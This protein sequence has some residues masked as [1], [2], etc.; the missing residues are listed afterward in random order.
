MG[1]IFNDYYHSHYIDK[2]KHLFFFLILV[3]TNLSQAYS[4]Y[5]RLSDSTFGFS[6]P[7]GQLACSVTDPTWVY[8]QTLVLNSQPTSVE[9]IGRCDTPLGLSSYQVQF[10]PT[11]PTCIFPS[12]LNNSTFTCDTVCPPPNT[13]NSITGACENQCTSKSGTL[14]QYFTRYP[15]S[16]ECIDYCQ[17]LRISGN[18]G[19]NELGQQG[20]YL[21]GKFNG[22]SCT[23]DNSPSALYEQGSPAEKCIK[24]GKSYGLVNGVVVCTS[25]GTAGSSPTS[26]ISPPVTTTT[27][28]APTVE[29]PNPTST[30]TIS[31]STTTITTPA[32]S[33]SPSGTQPTITE[34]KTN[35]DGSKIQESGQKDDFCSKNPNSK[36]CKEPKKTSCEENPDGPQCKH[37][38]EKYPESLSCVKTTDYIG[39]SSTLTSGEIPKGTVN[40][41][42]NIRNVTLTE[43][44][45]CPPDYSVTIGG[46]VIPFSYSWLCDYASSFK[47]LVVSFALLAA[48]YIVYGAL[49][50]S[51]A[52]VQGRLF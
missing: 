20:C 33:G 30:T 32:P 28:P 36:L 5:F 42:T 8:T 24:S 31:P 47:P 23:A 27:T 15:S 51:T 37:F 46:R 18:C 52:P 25:A 34:T 26:T 4:G 29:N 13:I 39:D 35:S 16:T 22:S 44:N 10:V 7:S 1:W 12:V 40:F 41:P 49:Q 3:H 45:T 50:G 6:Q 38:C 14:S 11:L 48:L 2:M 21:I 19:F 17:A 43:N 9:I